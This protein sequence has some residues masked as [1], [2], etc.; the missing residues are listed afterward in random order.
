MSNVV[1]LSYL[2][3]IRARKQMEKAFVANDWDAVKE[4]DA[5]VTHQLTQ[6]FDDPDRDN[7]ML[8]DELEYVLGLYARMVE[9]LPAAATQGWLNPEMRQV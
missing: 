4:Y 8:V 3:L 2:N 9:A 6:A 1:S 7:R 5:L